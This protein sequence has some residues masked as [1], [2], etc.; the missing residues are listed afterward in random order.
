[1]TCLILATRADF[2]LR[3]YTPWHEPYSELQSAPQYAAVSPQ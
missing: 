3:L 2:A 1:M